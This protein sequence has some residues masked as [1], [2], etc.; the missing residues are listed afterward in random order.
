MLT[1]SVDCTYSMAIGSPLVALSAILTHVCLITVPRILYV[2][3]IIHF[4]IR[5]WLWVP[6]FSTSIGDLS[7]LSP[8]LFLMLPL[9]SAT[10]ISVFVLAL[11]HSLPGCEQNTIICTTGSLNQTLSPHYLFWISPQAICCFDSILYWKVKLLQPAMSYFIRKK[12]CDLYFIY[13][14]L[15]FF[16][17]RFENQTFCLFS[18]EPKLKC[19]EC[20]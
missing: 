2:I 1:F 17:Q 16:C 18:P 9:A 5:L 4:Q 14:I 10:F 3:S 15:V 6:I 7:I 19:M 12:D 8:P 11:I 20:H 13:D